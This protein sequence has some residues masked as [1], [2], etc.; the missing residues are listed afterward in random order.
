MQK[1]KVP[2]DDNDLRS[3]AVLGAG[4]AAG[5]PYFYFRDPGKGIT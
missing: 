2:W 5:F 4:V 1:G 3:Q